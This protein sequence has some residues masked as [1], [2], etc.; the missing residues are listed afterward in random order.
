MARVIRIIQIHAEEVDCNGL[1]PL[2]YLSDDQWMGLSPHPTIKSAPEVLSP[3]SY[4]KSP[5]FPIQP[6]ETLG[7][8]NKQ[9]SRVSHIRDREESSR[10]YHR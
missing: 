9:C 5:S 1:M 7:R 6:V 4:L 3:E 10:K 8:S 2:L